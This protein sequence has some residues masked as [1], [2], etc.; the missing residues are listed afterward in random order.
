MGRRWCG[1]PHT[2]GVWATERACKVGRETIRDSARAP[3]KRD[4]ASSISLDLLARSQL[5]SLMRKESAG[6]DRPL[7]SASASVG[8]YCRISRPREKFSCKI[9]HFS[10]VIYVYMCAI[11]AESWSCLDIFR[12]YLSK[13]LETVK[14]TFRTL[15]DLMYLLSSTLF[16]YV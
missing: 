3:A 11:C 1:A 15:I 14:W 2:D 7:A 6:Y 9:V 4:R 13:V 8:R 5:S 16:A 10:N 12:A